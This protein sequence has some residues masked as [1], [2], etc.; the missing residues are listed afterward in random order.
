MSSGPKRTRWREGPVEGD[1]RGGYG[2]DTGAA[3]EG[4]GY[5]GDVGTVRKRVGTDWRLGTGTDY[6][7]A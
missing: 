2:G 3:R 6:P 4:D 7:P 1:R 5:G